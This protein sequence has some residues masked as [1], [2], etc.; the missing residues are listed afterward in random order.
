MTDFTRFLITVLAI[1]IVIAILAVTAPA[2]LRL[3][4]LS[5]D[6]SCIQKDAN[7]RGWDDYLTECWNSNLESVQ[8][9]A[10]SSDYG[11]F[12]VNASANMRTVVV[13]AEFAL[14]FG[15]IFLV[16]RIWEPKKY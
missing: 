7:I 16:L 11:N 10:E 5:E 2:N 15:L 8:E 3:F 13:L 4:I 9:V 1:V 12:I 14:C 6:R